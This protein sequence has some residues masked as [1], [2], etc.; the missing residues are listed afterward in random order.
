MSRKKNK[1]LRKAAALPQQEMPKRKVSSLLEEMIAGS[2]YGSVV[3][4]FPEG[5]NVRDEIRKSILEIEKIRNR[6]LICYLA[7]VQNPNI[8]V[9]TSIDYSD[10][11]PFSEMIDN[12]NHDIK[13]LDIMVV[14]PGGS[15]E[16]VAKF[17]NKLRPRFENV[18]FILPDIAMSAGTIFCLSG[19]EIIM[20]SR[21]HIGPIDPQIPNKN[22]FYIPA[23]ALLTIIQDIQQRGDELLSKGNSPLWTDIQILNNIEAKEIG[24]A[25]NASQFS[26]DLVKDYL[27]RYKFKT[28]TQHSDGRPVTDADKNNRATEIAIKLC[29]HGEWKTHSRGITREVAWDV[30]KLKILSTESIE[31]FQQEIR[32]LWAFVYYGF[33]NLNIAKIFISTEYAIF[34]A[35]TLTALSGR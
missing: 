28:W 15:A 7:N 25:I 1:G 30:C 10:D 23:Q 26:I 35:Q 12:I 22:G 18:T 33:E 31:G 32:K 5:M 29:N 3:D 13:D 4:C 34:R 14:T 24:M 16:Q 20:D 17:V 21:A 27:S 6:K 11:L 19:D 2:E 8:V 9:S